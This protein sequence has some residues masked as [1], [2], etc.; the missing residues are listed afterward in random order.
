M[1]IMIFVIEGV[2]RCLGEQFARDTLFIILCGLV[3]NFHFQF[4]PS[5]EKNND[6]KM[7]EGS[8]MFVSTPKPF[9]VIINERK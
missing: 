3:Q 4:D 1:K 6:D 9:K 2:R 8:F 5:K 7:I